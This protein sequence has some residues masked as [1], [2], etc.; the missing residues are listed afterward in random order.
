MFVWKHSEEVRTTASASE[1]WAHWKDA[2]HWPRW[3]KEL[4][5][6]RLE[7]EFVKG[8]KGKMKPAA[9]PEVKLTLGNVI[10]N[11][12]SSDIAK[13]PITKLV[14]DH[15]YLAPANPGDSAKIK[16]SVTMTGLLA[17]LFG[18]LIGTKIRLHSWILKRGA[19]LRLLLPVRR[20]DSAFNTPI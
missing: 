12:S 13:L 2:A 9:G 1:I 18:R 20:S 8:T 6:V 19:R 16:H 5:W 10:I 4:A 15:E 14:F 7:G 11:K 17:P 3:D